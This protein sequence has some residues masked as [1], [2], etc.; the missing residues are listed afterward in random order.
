M[1]KKKENDSQMGLVADYGFHTDV[2]LKAIIDTPSSFRYEKDMRDYIADN[3]HLLGIEPSRICKEENMPKGG[4]RKYAKFIIDLL[5]VDK[6]GRHYIIEFKKPHYHGSTDLANGLTQLNM[7]GMIYYELYGI[8]PK[9]ILISDRYNGY[10]HKYK[11][12]YHGNTI[13]YYL[14]KNDCILKLVN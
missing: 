2:K 14:L 12:R 11:K 1:K 7:Y 13:D 3:P 10:F 4:H 5:I 8:T 6:Y 9:L